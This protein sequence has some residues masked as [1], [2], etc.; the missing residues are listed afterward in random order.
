LR[1]RGRVRVR[2]RGRARAKV[3]AR[4]RVRVRV[5]AAAHVEGAE[6]GRAVRDKCVERERSGTEEA[7]YGE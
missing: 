1:V 7:V 3:G 6:R 2:A 5:H 4:A